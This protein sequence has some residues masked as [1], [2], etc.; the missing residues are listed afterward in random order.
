MINTARGSAVITNDLVKAIEENKILGACL[1]VLE[2]E[3]ASFENFFTDK[4]LPESF[5][6]LIDSDKVILSPH[7]AGWT[8]ESKF[9]LADTIVKKIESLINH[10]YS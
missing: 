6:Y 2:Y 7:V 3:K 1:D 9:K 10:Y 5:Q 4:N 8:V